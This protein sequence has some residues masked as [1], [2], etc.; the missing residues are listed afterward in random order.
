MSGEQGGVKTVGWYGGLGATVVRLG[1]CEEGE[2][3]GW[4]LTGFDPGIKY[5][6][7]VWAY[8]VGLGK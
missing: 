5:Q 7:G 6:G 4:S 2:G 1:V 8:F 3:D